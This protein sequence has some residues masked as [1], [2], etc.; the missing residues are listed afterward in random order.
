MKILENLGISVGNSLPQK[1]YSVII[2]AV[3][4]IGLS[5][6]IKGRYAEVID[7][8]NRMTA[9]KVAVDTP[10]GIRSDDGKVL[11][12]AFKADLTV[13]FAFQKMGQIL[14]PGCEYTGKL[15]TAPIGITRPEFLRKKKSAWHLKIRCAGN[16]ATKETGF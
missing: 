6:E 2:D 13:T 5:R 4:G 16:A 9:C 12:T 15:V 14:Y 7:Q 8:M 10:S 3:F 11:G 1:E